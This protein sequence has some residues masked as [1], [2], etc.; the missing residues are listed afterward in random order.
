MGHMQ[1][2]RPGTDDP[3]PYGDPHQKGLK[4]CKKEK[5]PC[6]NQSFS[7]GQ[8]RAGPVLVHTLRWSLAAARDLPPSQSHWHPAPQILED[9][10]R[11]IQ[12]ESILTSLGSARSCRS[13]LSSAWL[14]WYISM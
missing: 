12:G 11:S 3:Q 8:C 10:T 13:S 6:G 7:P 1:D 9:S 5:L 4:C 14:R 2:P